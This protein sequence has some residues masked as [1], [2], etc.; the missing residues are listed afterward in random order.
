MN[1][2]FIIDLTIE[3]MLAMVGKSVGNFQ[4]QRTSLDNTK[5][6]IKLAE[7]DNNNYTELAPYQEFTKEQILI[8]LQKPEWSNPLLII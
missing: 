8:E 7:G 6:I 5:I 2:Y 4:D 1:R 3:N